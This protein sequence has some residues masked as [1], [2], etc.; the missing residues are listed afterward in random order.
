MKRLNIKDARKTFQQDQE[1]FYRN[2]Q[3]TKQLK[4]KVLK[5]ENFEDFWAGTT[6]QD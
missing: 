3:G 2:T 6:R 1:M 5:M 4:G